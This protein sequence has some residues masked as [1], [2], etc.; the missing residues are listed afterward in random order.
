MLTSKSD[1]IDKLLGF[2]IGADDYVTKPFSIMELKA[3]INA[4]LRR[5]SD[6][7]KEIDS[8]TFASIDLDF[9]KQEARKNK[10]SLQ[11]S[12]KE[13]EIL[14]FFIQREGEV[15][16]RDMLLDEVWGYDVFPTTRTVDNYILNLRKKIE[17]D[18]NN[19]RHIITMHKSGYKFIK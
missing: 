9:K 7:R 10:K 17:D 2:E 16:S 4:L 13:F 5:S 11:L 12:A 18:P 6:L 1:E 14:H 3:R 15:V 19:P 8:Y